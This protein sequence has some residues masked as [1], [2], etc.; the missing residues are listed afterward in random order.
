M[1]TYKEAKE[2]VLKYLN[3]DKIDYKLVLYLP[4]IEIKYGWVFYY[5]QEGVFHPK[6]TEI[7]E[8]ISNFRKEGKEEDEI[9]NL[10]TEEERRI[11]YESAG[12]VGHLPIFI[13]KENGKMKAYLPPVE[14]IEQDV[15]KEKT[16]LDYKWE[17]CFQKNEDINLE[18]VRALYKEVSSRY[19]LSL[20][21]WYKKIKEGKAFI[22]TKDYRNLLNHKSILE[23]I[24]IKYQIIEIR[25][26]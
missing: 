6:L 5:D 26:K 8:K 23:S 10:L 2:K 18:K 17:L 14:G 1:L 16:R 24:G 7:N 21:E 20:T 13:D 11:E 3:E 22:S 15:R 19:E 4:G 25:S 9:L 12:L